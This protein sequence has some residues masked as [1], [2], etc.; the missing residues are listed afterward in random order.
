MS[1]S[2]LPR[3]SVIVPV[4]DSRG[5]VQ[6]C[7]ESLE[8][9]TD[10]DFEVVVVD[11]R[12]TD[13]SVEIAK[14]I[15]DR[16]GFRLVALEVNKGQAVARNEG[17]RVATGPILAF[18]DSDVAVPEDWLARY[19]RLLGA[20][21]D[22]DVIC[23]G[24]VVSA[25]DP[26][27]ALFASHEA[28]FR[29]LSLPSLELRSFTT[30]NC[31][32]RR[33]VFDEAGGCPEYYVGKGR[34]QRQRKA[35]AVNEDSELGYLVS[36]AGHRILWTHDNRVRHFFRDTW[37]G[38]LRAQLASAR[39]GVLSVFRFPGML[40][41]DDLYSGEKVAPQLAAVALMLLSLP[42]AF[43]GMPG[44]V[45]VGLVEASGLLFFA[46]VHRRFF[47]YLGDEM[48]DYGHFRIYLWMVLTRVVW[49][50][51]AALGVR[52]GLLMLWNHGRGRRWQGGA[53]AR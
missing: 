13:G 12:S 51:G 1:A 10:P 42:A 48:R 36:A 28:F 31:V 47:A 29:R 16:A 41:T 40:W 39:Y 33:D 22:V 8:R 7:L 23:S 35:V 21:A 44:L 30:A 24:Y 11:D 38:Y 2:D 20:H 6:R 49:L 50:W 27:P 53:V 5:T 15:C 26:I 43:L 17:V 14:G 9:Q 25:G 52:D 32:M 46:L 18:V 4:H 19:R 3:I 37:G 45:A 34:D